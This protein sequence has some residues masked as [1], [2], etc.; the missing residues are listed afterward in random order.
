MLQFSQ[1]KSKMDTI[2]AKVSKKSINH[3]QACAELR[4]YMVM[5]QKRDITDAIELFKAGWLV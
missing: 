4:K 5:Y 3:K 2:R 1:V